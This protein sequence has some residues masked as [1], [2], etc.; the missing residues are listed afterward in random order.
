[1]VVE[2]D[3]RH[4]FGN[5]NTLKQ[6]EITNLLDHHGR[7]RAVLVFKLARAIIVHDLMR[8]ELSAAGVWRLQKDAVLRQHMAD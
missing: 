8:F 5:S 1:M 6:S 3:K 2:H 4:T 7:C